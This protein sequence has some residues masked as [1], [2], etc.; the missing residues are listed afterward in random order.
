MKIPAKILAIVAQE[1]PKIWNVDDRI[2]ILDFIY[3][4]GVKPDWISD[5]IHFNSY[6]VDGERPTIMP[7][8]GRG[9]DKLSAHYRV[10]HSTIELGY[11][12]SVID[13]PDLCD[14]YVESAKCRY[15]GEELT[16]EQLE[17]LSDDH[18]L[19]MEMML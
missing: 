14:V 1:Y 16:E 12:G 7:T 13:Y 5:I 17:E 3:D 18:A 4:A 6:P 11:N 9:L 19:K 10:D 2:A 8:I 15:T